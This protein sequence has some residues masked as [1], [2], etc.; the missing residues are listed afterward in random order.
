MQNAETILT[1]LVAVI[2]VAALIQL[3]V[4]FVM[5]LALKKGLKLAG[6]YATEMQSKVVPVLEHSKALIHT[7]KDL[8]TRLQPKLEATA[9][10]LAELS[11][12]AN[13]EAKKIQESTDEITERLRRQAARVDGMTTDAL[14]GVDRAGHL[15]NQAVTIPARQVAGVVAAAKAVFETLRKPAPRTRPRT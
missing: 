11:Q 10:N 4:L 14:N 9:T 7:T 15:L 12:V 3:V 6:E 8:I 5:L 13:A 1:I 2:A